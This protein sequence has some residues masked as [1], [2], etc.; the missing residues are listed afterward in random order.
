VRLA[1]PQVLPSEVELM[2]LQLHGRMTE[3]EYAG[4]RNWSFAGKGEVCRELLK[5]Q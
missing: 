3:P 5:D 2:K 1:H 4:G